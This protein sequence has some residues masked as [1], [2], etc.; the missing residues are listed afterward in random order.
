VDENGTVQENFL[1]FVECEEG[2]S[3]AAIGALILESCE[4]VGLEFSKCRGLGFDGASN[5]SGKTY[6][7][8]A[9][10]KRSFPKAT[11]VHCAAHRLNLCVAKAN[12]LPA[13]R[14]VFDTVTS[15]ANF[16]NYSPT[17]QKALEVEIESSCISTRK[18]KILPLCRTRWVERLNA[19]AVFV[20]LFDVILSTFEC[21]WF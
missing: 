20:E 2:T 11:Y 7:A 19:L 18:S 13:I 12:D 5:M 8:A 14:S 3:G 16:F 21:P 10:I 4:S 6:G 1:M 15:V 17:R 9:V